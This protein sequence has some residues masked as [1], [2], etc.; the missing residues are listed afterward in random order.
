MSNSNTTLKTVTVDDV[1]DA[2]LMTITGSVGARGKFFRI[3]YPDI[4]HPLVAQ[5]VLNARRL[6]QDAYHD[7]VEAGDVE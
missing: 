3:T 5:A 2:E 1:Y 7:A 6:I 4:D